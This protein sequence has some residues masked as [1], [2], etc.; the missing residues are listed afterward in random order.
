MNTQ[1]PRHYV[2]EQPA[3][4]EPLIHAGSVHA[5]DGEMALLIAR[6]VFARRP[7]RVAMW[8]VRDQEI[9]SRTKEQ[10]EA[11]PLGGRPPLK[12]SPAPGGAAGAFQIFAKVSHKGVC[13]HQGEVAAANPE[14][15]LLLAMA[16]FPLAA[17]VWWVIPDVALVKS[18][19]AE[20][21]LLYE[22]TPGKIY[23]HEN[24]YHVRTMMMEARKREQEAGGREQGR[25]G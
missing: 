2:F 4:G 6:D 17:M 18:D 3:P 11:A 8:M 20:T 23:R 10:I 25:E 1:W 22:S 24:H 7:E 21:G 9:F 13:I 12:A 14:Q 15:A 5:P 16:K 19:P